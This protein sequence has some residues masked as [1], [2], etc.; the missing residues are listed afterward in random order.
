[1]L[2]LLINL[3]SSRV[4]YPFHLYCLHRVVLQWVSWNWENKVTLC[5]LPPR[6]NVAP[7]C[8]ENRGEMLHQEPALPHLSPTS[9]HL[10]TGG[11]LPPYTIPSPNPT[12]RDEERLWHS[13][14][15]PITSPNRR[16][17]IGG[18]RLLSSPFVLRGRNTNKPQ[19]LFPAYV[20]WD[21]FSIAG[22]G[23]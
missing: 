9:L 22:P 19:C 11:L 10:H 23:R 14:W 18:I 4:K 5:F 3:I 2:A 12:P 20:N 6:R 16:N 15:M 8:S 1:M 17:T 7:T 13:M 21:P